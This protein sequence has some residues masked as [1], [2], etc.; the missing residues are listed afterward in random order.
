L[1]FI[2]QQNSVSFPSSLPPFLP[3]SLPPF[4]RS[5]VPLLPSSL[6]PYSL[7]LTPF[8]PY[9]F[10]PLLPYSP[11]SLPSF[12]SKKFDMIRNYPPS[13]GLGTIFSSPGAR[14]GSDKLIHFNDSLYLFG[15]YCTFCILNY[16]AFFCN[17]LLI[18]I[19]ILILIY[20]IFILQIKT[21][22]STFSTTICGNLTWQQKYGF[23]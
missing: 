18:L 5:S 11:S 23:G 12:L 17:I 16:Y 22:T 1:D 19:L 21:G 14:V 9:S 4:L 2:D 7:T 8:L 6:T 3:S 20:F 10:P 13:L 15:G